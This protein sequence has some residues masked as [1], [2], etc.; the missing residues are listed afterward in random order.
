MMAREPDDRYQSA[1]EAHVALEEALAASSGRSGAENAGG[2]I[3]G[4]LAR[5]LRR[6]LGRLGPGRKGTGG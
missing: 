6:G 5:A 2:G 1:I 4:R 3:P